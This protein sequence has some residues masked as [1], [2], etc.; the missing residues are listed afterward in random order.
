MSG[1]V[2]LMTLIGGVGTVYGPF[3]GALV[4]VTL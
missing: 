4:L 1:E 3:V 2:D